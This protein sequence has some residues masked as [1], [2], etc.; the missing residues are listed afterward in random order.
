ML[1]FLATDGPKKYVI[2]ATDI[3]SQAETENLHG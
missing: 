3:A 1:S 2:T